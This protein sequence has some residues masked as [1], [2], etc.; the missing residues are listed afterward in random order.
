MNKQLSL[1]AIS[2]LCQTIST[3]STNTHTRLSVVSHNWAP[4]PLQRQ[5]QLATSWSAQSKR[6]ATPSLL[7]LAA[8]KRRASCRLYPKASRIAWMRWNMCWIGWS[9][10]TARAW[11]CRPWRTCWRRARM[12]ASWQR[13]AW[14]KWRAGW[15]SWASTEAWTDSLAVARSLSWKQ[16]LLIL[17][18]TTSWITKYVCENS[19]LSKHSLETQ[20]LCISRPCQHRPLYLEITSEWLLERLSPERGFECIPVRAFVSHVTSST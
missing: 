11:P 10:Q 19:F 2:I 8:Q 7:S 20:T 4:L 9:F 16:Y 13:F 12:H 14:A 15:R 17:A 18:T 3:G 6:P 5:R 1:S